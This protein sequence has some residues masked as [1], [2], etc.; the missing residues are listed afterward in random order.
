MFYIKQTKNWEFVIWFVA[1]TMT[2]VDVL[3]STVAT[4][5]QLIK[6]L[7]DNSEILIGHLRENGSLLN[8]CL[9]KENRQPD[10]HLFVK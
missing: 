4:N 7:N 1:I 2:R 10:D 8:W 9:N 3:I 6:I 5:L